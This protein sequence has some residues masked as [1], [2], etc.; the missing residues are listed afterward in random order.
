MDLCAILTPVMSDFAQTIAD[1]GPLTEEDQKKAGA[2]IAGDIDAE[3]RNFL[4]T[5]MKLFKDGTI[6]PYNTK[7]FVH[8][9]VYNA[10]DEEWQDKIDLALANIANQLRLIQEFMESTETPDE[11]PQ[12]QTM[13]EQLWQMKQKI[14]E[15]HDV[16]IF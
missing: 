16:F 9:D 11:S 3:H 4:K 2:P 15:H 1:S 7:S 6:D 13:V 5:L 10:L 8:D 14:E 12:L